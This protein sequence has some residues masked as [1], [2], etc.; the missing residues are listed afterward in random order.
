MATGSASFFASGCQSSTKGGELLRL[1]SVL[2]HVRREAVP[3]PGV[4]VKLQAQL[5]SGATLPLGGVS[6]SLGMKEG[7]RRPQGFNLSMSSDPYTSLRKAKRGA[8]SRFCTLRPLPTHPPAKAGPERSQLGPFEFQRKRSSP[9]S[10]SDRETPA[11]R[12]AQDES[13]CSACQGWRWA[14]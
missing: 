9:G 13:S 14:G 2:P 12:R 1:R 10:K 6:T 5:V 8:M 11:G 7:R 3:P 4:A